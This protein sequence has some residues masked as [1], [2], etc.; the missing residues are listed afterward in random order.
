MKI[1]EIVQPWYEHFV[2]VD[3][4]MLFELLL[5]ADYLGIEP[6]KD[7]VWLAIAIIIEVGC[8]LYWCACGEQ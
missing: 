2:D 5:A 1:S 6:L 8:V 4:V 3:E 7:L